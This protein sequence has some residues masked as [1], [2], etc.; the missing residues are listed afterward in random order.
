MRTW[1]LLG[2]LALAGCDLY[3]G[4]TEKP[5]PQCGCGAD[6]PYQELRDPQ[7][8]ECEP[9][10]GGGCDGDGGCDCC[11]LGA[12]IAAIPDWGSCGGACDALDENTCLATAGC[13][14]EYTGFVCPPNADC[15]ALWSGVAFWTCSEV[16]PSGAIEGGGC[17]GLDAQTCAEH[18][19]CASAYQVPS[20]TSS[21]HAFNQCFPEPAAQCGGVEC[22]AGSHCE[23]QCAKCDPS[24]NGGCMDD[25]VI[26]CVPDQ[27]SCVAVDCA[28]GSHCEETCD[29]GP[30]CDPPGPCPPPTCAATCVPDA[31]D[32][33]ECYELVTCNSAPPACPP[34]TTPGVEDGCYTGYC[35]PISACSHDP[36]TCDGPLACDV[37]PPACP[38]GTEPGIA[39]GCWS[40]FC[41]PDWACTSTPT[42]ESITDEKTCVSRAD[43]TAIYDGMN[44]TCDPA[45]NCMCQDQTFARCTTGGKPD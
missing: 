7:T 40:G 23:E 10:G 14:A 32:P 22:A 13:H 37:A 30:V 21:T 1:L 8:G 36:G 12:D 2:F 24:G 44:C 4:N 42:C 26:V 38:T 33:G 20:D 16:P 11:G 5:P 35:I 6:H 28:P 9:W 34:S 39:N 29:A 19:D 41:I 18:D 3:F 27:D 31:G 25:C 17:W 15:A 43:C 45:G